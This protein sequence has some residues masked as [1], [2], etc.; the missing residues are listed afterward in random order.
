M[1][2]GTLPILPIF[3]PALA[4]ALSADCAPGPGVLVLRSKHKH[5][6]QP[7]NWNRHINGKFINKHS[8]LYSTYLSMCY[9]KSHWDY[10]TQKKSHETHVILLSPHY[11][12]YGAYLTES[13]IKLDEWYD[14]MY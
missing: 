1:H 5:G 8:T 14:N 9:W 11:C 2:L 3:I 10:K 13:K 6:M 4:R 12:H 7:T